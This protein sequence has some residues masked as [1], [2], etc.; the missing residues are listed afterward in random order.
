MSLTLA[1]ALAMPVYSLLAVEPSATAVA[2][3]DNFA[4]QL[5]DRV[6][7]S[8]V[9]VKYTFTGETV[10][11]D[12]VV[13]GIVINDH[14]LVMISLAAVNEMIPDEQ[15]KHFKIIIPQKD[16]DNLEIDADFQGRDERSML[17]FVKAKPIAP[18]TSPTTVPT[19]PAVTWAP[20]Q[21]V[22]SLPKIGETV[23]S[24]GMLPKSGGYHTFLTRSVV[25]S[26]LRGPVK[27]VMVSG[28]GLASPGAPVF[29]AQGQAIGIVGFEPP[30]ELSLD[31]DIHDQRMSTYHMLSQMATN[32]FFIP[33]KE[34]A[35]GLSDPPSIDHPVPLAWTGLP[36]QLLTGL[37]KNDAALFGLTNQ[38][39]IQINDILPGSPAEKAGLAKKDVIVKLD[40]QPL[41]RGDQPEELP[42]ILH[43]KLIMHK[44]GDVVT[45]TITTGKDKPLRDV[46]VTLQPEP[47]RMNTAQRYWSDDIGFGV[48]E[49]VLLDRYNLKLKKSD[50]DG[51]L[52][53]ILKEGGSAASAGLHPNDMVIQVNGQPVT[54]L[55]SFKSTY[56]EFRKN[57]P[58]EAIVMLVHR[59]SGDE[60]IRIEPPQ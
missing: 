47:K 57:Q 52:V 53:T 5:Y 22:Q 34:F 36:D 37:S 8:L 51:V 46:K 54:D 19:T 44:P 15:L 20:L 4:Q 18:T 60:T 56:D 11:Q 1:A 41:E 31:D 33:A 17:A 14:G 32:R 49:M 59:G 7:P 42:Y 12:V 39:A 35:I 40:G 16:A 3:D 6:S 55:D 27:Q 25:S 50:K 26:Y 29:N 23:Y 45:F 30:A 10:Q 13:P 38:P 58:H 43:R 24:I 2:A 9:A 48:R 21:F 28:G